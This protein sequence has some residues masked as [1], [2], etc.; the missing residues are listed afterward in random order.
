MLSSSVQLRLPRSGEDRLLSRSSEERGMA[1]V[2]WLQPQQAIDMLVDRGTQAPEAW[3]IVADAMRQGRLR[4][5]AASIETHFEGEPP[6]QKDDHEVLCDAWSLD[7][8]PPPGHVFWSQGDARL[9]LLIAPM[10]IRG[11]RL[12]RAGAELLAFDQSER[13]RSSSGPSRP[14]KSKVPLPTDDAIQAKMQELMTGGLSR[15]EAAKRI[16][17]EPGFEAVGNEHA[18]RTVVNKVPR[19]RPRKI[20]RN[21]VD[22]TAL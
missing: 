14:I 18:R 9:M 7:A 5:R 12:S 19:G 17:Q 13:L 16:R 6:Y 11:A 20:A 15:D 3:K 4:C 21:Q 1:D 8:V 22:R 2:D 10:E